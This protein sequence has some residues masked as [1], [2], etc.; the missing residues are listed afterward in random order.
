MVEKKEIK[1]KKELEMEK[2]EKEVPV[3][4]TEST[5]P[6]KVEEVKVEKVEKLQDEPETE[7]KSEWET[8]AERGRGA[9]QKFFDD[10]IGTFRERGG[11]FEKA[12]SEYTASAP[13]KL[14]TD[15]IE[16]DGSLIVKADLPGVKKEDIVIDLT[17]D[18]IEIF[19]KFEEETEEEGKNFIK[20]E[21][22]YGEAR[23]SLILPE[24]V[25]VKE[26]SAKFDNG[27]LTVTL[28]KLEE[29]KRFQVKVD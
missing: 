7:T 9:A 2:T 17:D 3:A 25:K 6:E 10:M 5:E 27:V 23:R 1:T 29:K 8:R 16:T 11:D 13:S 12:L 15:L 26:T 4:K 28:P 21:R 14:T 22:R 18:S 19:A 24:A 20:K